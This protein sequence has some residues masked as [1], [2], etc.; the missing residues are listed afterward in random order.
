MAVW[1]PVL[2]AALPYVSSIVA[3]TLPAFT[4]RKGQDASAELV[5][6]QIAE[7]QEAVTG[8]AEAVKVL[9]A[10]LEKT[11]KAMETSEVESSHRISEHFSQQLAGLRETISRCESAATLA[12]AQATRQDGVTAAL[13]MRIEELESHFEQRRTTIRRREVAVA[14]IALLA[15]LLAVIALFR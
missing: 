15:L 4:S 2:K 12:Q 14:G 7:L 9:A 5:T 8:N 6:Q 11:L 13:L 1:I 10:Q 3:A